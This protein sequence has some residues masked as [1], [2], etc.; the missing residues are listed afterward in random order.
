MKKVFCMF[1]A[2]LMLVSLLPTIFFN[3]SVFAAQTIVTNE[4]TPITTA[5]SKDL[6]I[7]IGSVNASPNEIIS[8]P[9]NVTNVPKDGILVFNMTIKYDETKLEYLDYE[10]GNII[11]NPETNFSMQKEQDGVLN[12]LFMDYNFANE[13]II[14]DGQLINFHFKVLETSK[15]ATSISV[16]KISFGDTKLK[17]LIETTVSGLINIS[18]CAV[19]GVFNV[20]IGSA[21]GNKGDILSIPVNFENVPSEGLSTCEMNI[22][23][24]PLLVEFLDYESGNIINNKTSSFKIDKLPDGN[25][26]LIFLCN[27]TEQPITSDGL[28]ANLEF[29]ILDSYFTPITID[30]TDTNFTNIY[31]DN[32]VVMNFS[33]QII[34]YIKPTP[35][36]P[37]KLAVAVDEAIE[38]SESLLSIPVTL[39]NVPN[40]GISSIKLNLHY[41]SDI[42][43]YLSYKK[44]NTASNLTVTKVQDGILSLV[45]DNA[46][47]NKDNYIKDDGEL[48]TIDFEILTPDNKNT[49]ISL[50]DASFLDKL[51]NPIDAELEPDLVYVTGLLTPISSN[52]KISVDPTQGNTG[53]LIEVPIKFTNVPEGGIGSADMTINYDADFLEYVS[54][55]QGSIVDNAALNFCSTLQY[56]GSI[57]FMLQYPSKETCISTD[58]IFATITFKV[59]QASDSLTQ[60]LISQ[61]T[62]TNRNLRAFYKSTSSGFV[63]ISGQPTP[64]D[65]DLQI[66]LGSAQVKKGEIVAIPVSLTNVTS[67]PS[68]LCNIKYDSSKLNYDHYEAGSI[69]DFPSTSFD[70]LSEENGNLKLLFLNYLMCND[71]NI[72]RDGLLVTLFFKAT[73]NSCK[74]PL[75]FDSIMINNNNLDI[76][77]VKSKSGYI[78]I[79]EGDKYTISGYISSDFV[80]SNSQTNEG[81]VIALSGTNIMATTD[82]KG[83]FE[84]KSVPVGIYNI[85]VTK[86]NFLSRKI[87]NISIDGNKELSTVSNPLLLW[88]GDIEIS[89]IKDGAINFEDIMAICKMFNSLSGD[90]SYK[91]NMDFNIDGAI[92]LEDI[93]IIAKH[94]NKTSS[95]YK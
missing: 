22:K 51:L 83:Y 67:I 72:Q 60:I 94:F 38:I 17:E 86:S 89:G 18:D 71:Y 87:E 44:G 35:P 84:I 74:T 14:S 21:E 69:I 49:L 20:K 24:N 31:N 27:T 11:I 57:K 78:D 4:T 82:D 54:S 19:P 70:V 42:L 91:E 3:T 55:A 61:P 9:I 79:L 64:P 7:T 32:L 28:F 56:P 76:L 33:G 90:E 68:L 46:I 52:L 95:D 85:E 92:N 41:D 53:D 81:F 26:K 40:E 93:M 8:V 47:T 2:I 45:V 43:G 66:N 12:M 29:K 16:S 13:H 80:K 6:T 1:L 5:S 50:H 73:E 77:N 88:C 39:K 58:G 65:T 75:N 23:Y 63:N 10:H 34:F 30:I 25:I 37:K 62:V 59:L 15:S 48:L 36:P